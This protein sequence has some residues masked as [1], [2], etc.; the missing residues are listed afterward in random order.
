V[1][2]ESDASWHN[3]EV[4]MLI[5]GF[6]GRWGAVLLVAAVVG[7]LPFV[8]KPS[9]ALPLFGRKYGM[10]CTSCHVAAPRLNS[11][12]MR[13]KQNGYRLPGTHGESPW[14]S[15]AKEFPLALV[16]N[17][18]YHLS[19]T[20][21]D[22]GNGSHERT[23]VGGFEQQ[24]VEFHSAGTLA[25]RVTFHFDNNFAG[26]GG[27][28]E[29][30]MAF[31]QLDDVVKDGA[32]NVKAGIFDADTPYLADS[33]KTTL[34]EYLS[35]ITL[36]G[37]GI[38]LNG[39]RSDWMYA[40]GLINSSRDPDSALAHKPDSKTFNQLENVYGWVTR[41]LG[42]EM[43][44]ARVF[45]DRQDPRK[46]NVTSSQH[47][48]AELNAL[49][50]RGRFL[51]IPGYT[52]ESFSDEP[53]GIADRLHTGLLEAMFLLGKDSHWVLTARFE[54]Q[55]VPKVNGATAVA[56]RS[57]GVL[58]M[59]WYVNPNARVGVDW[60]HASNNVHDPVTDDLRAFVWVGY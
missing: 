10:Q 28:L 34:T 21:T 44:T 38:E 45:L 35:P 46:P 39:Q 42:G 20:N 5:R 32:L 24:Q 41:D 9:H 13:F 1:A 7:T 56:D 4:A 37:R 25:E 15:T 43:V 22:L 48:Q 8:S 40:A 49:V 30:G 17:V 57:Q 18:A 26:A 47:L 6:Q 55:Y 3:R 51:L 36:D 54:H 52:Y 2:I 29:S 27:P 59:A 58:N 11:F 31:V 50:D 23:N 14:D 16:G 12:G 33:R 19:S 60:A 53:T